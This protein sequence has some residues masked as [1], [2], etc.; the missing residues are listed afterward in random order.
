MFTVPLVPVRLKTAAAAV[1]RVVG[2]D[3]VLDGAPGGSP[4]RTTSRHF[5]ARSGVLVAPA[6]IVRILA[7]ESQMRRGGML[8]NS[9]ACDLPPGGVEK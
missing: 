8:W 2:M 1:P 4:E 6:Q 3:G 7:R 9:P 5:P